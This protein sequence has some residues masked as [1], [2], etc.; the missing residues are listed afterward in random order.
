MGLLAKIDRTSL[1]RVPPNTR[2]E[3]GIKDGVERLGPDSGEVQPL[4]ITVDPER[5]TPER[6]ALCVSSIHSRLVGVRG[7]AEEIRQ[8]A[9][10]Y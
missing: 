7:S 2:V 1:E 3:F 4:F 8:V 5:D 9:L 10:A 6:L